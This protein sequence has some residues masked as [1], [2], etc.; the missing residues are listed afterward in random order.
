[1]SASLPFAWPKT[2]ASAAP[3]T[4]TYRRL[5][6][7]TAIC[8]VREV[9]DHVREKA[10]FGD[11]PNEQAGEGRVPSAGEAR[12]LSAWPGVR[13]SIVQPPR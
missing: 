12:S 2:T 10:G 4:P 3:R 6:A 11:E 5:V 9:E 8:V 1:M 7:D 13:N